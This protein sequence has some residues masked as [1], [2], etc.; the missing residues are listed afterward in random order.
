MKPQESQARVAKMCE[1]V[2]PQ[3]GSVHPVPQGKEH[4][5]HFHF[6]HRHCWGRPDGFPR[7]LDPSWDVTRSSQMAM[8]LLC[9][10]GTGF[11]SRTNIQKQ[12]SY[13][14]NT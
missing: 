2:G 9:P 12:L 8:L 13:H 1:H 4:Y 5:G 11:W 6:E 14:V 3:G 10:T 7:L